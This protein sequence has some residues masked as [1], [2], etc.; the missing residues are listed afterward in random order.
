MRVFYTTDEQT[1]LSLANS[2]AQFITDRVR[3]VSDLLDAEVR[4]WSEYAG[5][6]LRMAGPVDGRLVDP[7]RLLQQVADARANG[8]LIIAD[9]T[10]TGFGR[11]GMAWGH[12]RWD[13]TPDITVIGGAGGGGFPFGAVVA[14]AEYFTEELRSNWHPLRQAG[15]PAICAAGAATLKAIDAPLLT[16]VQDAYGGFNAGLQELQ[17]QFPQLITGHSGVGLLHFLQ[18]D[19]PAEAQQFVH[20]CWERGLLLTP[21]R[22]KTI[23]LTPPLIASE[24]EL[25]RGV[26]LMAS[27]CLEWMY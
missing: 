19:N 22:S 10:L 23:V 11:T 26:D 3:L 27:A 1:A 24:L 14:P 17:E 20:A 15:N 13:F 25:R 9:E 21:T 2:L 18:F 12:H 4:N 8:A 16:H 6:I 5:L 7:T